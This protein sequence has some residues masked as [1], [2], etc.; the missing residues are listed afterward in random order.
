[1]IGVRR[2]RTISIQ[3]GEARM[4]EKSQLDR[5][6]D[7]VINLARIRDEML[8]GE[9]EEILHVALFVQRQINSI[10]KML[11]ERMNNDKK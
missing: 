6:I 4:T 8:S 5:M 7:V 2:T 11:R 10:V 3:D 9:Y 1:M